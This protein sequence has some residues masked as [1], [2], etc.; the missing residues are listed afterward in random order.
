[1]KM[2]VPEASKLKTYD[3]IMT[4]FKL[5]LPLSQY[6]A[7]IRKLMPSLSNEF[8]H[9]VWLHDIFGA[10]ISDFHVVWLHDIFLTINLI[11]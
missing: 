8:I 6:D 7:L 10:T 3:A 11:F 4:P 9:V 1:V 2:K 5:G